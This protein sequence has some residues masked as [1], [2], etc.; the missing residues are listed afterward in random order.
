MGVSGVYCGM[1]KVLEVLVCIWDVFGVH[2]VY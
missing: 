2:C 1:C